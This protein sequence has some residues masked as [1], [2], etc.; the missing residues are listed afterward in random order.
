MPIAHSPRAPVSI[1][2]PRPWAYCDLCGFRYLHENLSWEK[3]WAGAA[4][5]RTGF[6][7]CHECLDVPNPNGKKPIRFY[8]DPKPV[9]DPRPGF[10][11]SQQ[12]QNA[13]LTI[14]E[15]TQLV[16]DSGAQF[17][18]DEDTAETAVSDSGGTLVDESGA[19][20]DTGV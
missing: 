7:V 17:V 20:F 11:Q 3:I 12:Q 4:L 6:L 13:G 16:D 18:M 10:L 9:R 5:I 19:G 8:P 15:G 2:K 14:D 1:S